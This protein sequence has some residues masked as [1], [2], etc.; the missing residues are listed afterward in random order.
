M[1][2]NHKE[3][4]CH[5][6]ECHCH[7]DH[8]DHHDHDNHHDHCHSDSC[9][10]GHSH[11]RKNKKSLIIRLILGVLI[12]S[13][14]IA[15]NNLYLY[16]ISYL[17]FGY[18]VITEGIR[19]LTKKRIFSEHILMSI[20]SVGAFILGEYLEGCAVMLLYQM[21]E[22]FCDIASEK[23]EKS[24]KELIDIKPEFANIYKGD[25]I[26]KILPEDL[27][28]NDIVAVTVG[29]KIP[30]D[31][32]IIEGETQIDT[33]KMTGEAEY[34]YKTAGDEVISG[35]VNMGSM[36]KIKITKAY[37]DSNVS[38]V[39]KL[40]DEIQKN[41]SEPEKFITKFAKYYTPSVLVIALIVAFCVPLLFGCEFEKWIYRALVFLVVSCPC[42]L[43]ISVPLA[44]FT[45]HSKASK[46]GILI[47]G[48]VAIEKL[49]KIKNFCFDKTGTLT[50]GSFKL[51]G[52]NFI[53][54]RE[55]AFYY[56]SHAEFYSDHPLSKPIIREYEKEISPSNISDYTE[57]AGKGIS[58]LVD[59]K[60]VLV[61][62]EA[63][64]EDNNIEIK[65]EEYKNTVT[66]LAV[67]NEY[68]G[69]VE[70][71]DGIKEESF[72]AISEL[73]KQRI[74]T[75]IL[76]GDMKNSV[77]EVSKAL[78]VDSFYA[79][80][81]PQD[82]VKIISEIKKSSPVA[83]LGDGINDAPA[84]TLA[85]VGIS[86]GLEGTDAAIVASDVV[87][88]TD[89]IS[90]LPSIYDI[91]KKTMQ[92]VWEIIIASV[93]VKMLIMILGTLGIANLWLAVFGDVG[94][95]I[96]AVLNALRAGK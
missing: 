93:G 17:I 85:D 9:S 65:K 1:E 53:K 64:M 27:E 2:H 13:L 95:C 46:M 45:A 55:S 80:L 43:V 29:E 52:D 18:D 60:I 6:H 20:A 62:N 78:G 26:E 3:H 87:V 10:C 28:V 72:E 4:N 14:G 71:T 96:L 24:I 23:S 22:Y 40:I 90:K 77:E 75:T 59:E 81:M 39:S 35:S 33:S 69:Y 48:S 21:G 51:L 92:I 79:E 11:G 5:N 42:S 61:G 67:D 84:L 73:K 49:C 38:K 16:I 83:F 32:V 94:M 41:K 36:I 76:S 89:D 88:L 31:G 82:K 44:F 54:D 57:I 12:F 91:S 56:L 30:S 37:N 47:K 8:C 7:H 63:L 25:K 66:H 86:M 50:K 15:F 19:Q 70:F 74:K 58:V 68:Y 34:S